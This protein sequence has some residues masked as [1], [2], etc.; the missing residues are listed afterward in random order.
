MNN[1]MRPETEDSYG[2]KDLQ[3]VILNIAQYIDTLCQSHGINYRL[4]GGSALGSKRHG[5]FIK[6][7]DYLD[8]LMTTT[9]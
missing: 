9:E 2:L 8:V 3:N 6:W 1:L 5:R 7:Y 4:M